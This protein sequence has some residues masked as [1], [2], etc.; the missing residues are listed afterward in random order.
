[1]IAL[2]RHV[3]RGFTDDDCGFMAAAV[4]FQIFFSLLPLLLLLVGVFGFFLTSQQLRNEV[5]VL[6]RDV[7]PGGVDRRLVDEIVNSGGLSFGIGLLGTIW[8]V[9]AIYATLD[10]ALRSVIRGGDRSF[11]RGRLQGLA[12]AGFLTILAV[13]SFALSFVMQAA[14]GWLRSVGVAAT[15]RIALEIVSPIGGLAA[16]FVLFYVVYRVVPRRRLPIMAVAVGAIVAAVLWE[17]AKIAFAVLTRELAVFRSYGILAL[18]AGLLT[19]IYLTALILL[20]GAEVMK[21]WSERRTAPR[22]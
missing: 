12:F 14:A 4:A 5:V 10:R 6:L 9:T 13:G 15:Q 11:I 19:W 16:G 20:L 22:P 8:G 7:S 2:A 3:W 1:M 17:V 18:A 21:A